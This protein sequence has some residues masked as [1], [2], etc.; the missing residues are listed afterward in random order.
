MTR[1]I[2]TKAL[3]FLSAIATPAGR[4]KGKRLD[5]GKHP[6]A[7]VKACEREE[8][9]A[10]SQLNVDLLHSRFQLTNPSQLPTIL[11]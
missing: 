3:H 8:A 1:S 2:M 11:L 7:E 6:T 4:R 5:A 10:Q 9:T